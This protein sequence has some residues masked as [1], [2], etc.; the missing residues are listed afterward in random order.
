MG[1]RGGSR[2]RGPAPAATAAGRAAPATRAIPERASV[3]VRT[4]GARDPLLQ[5]I[6]ALRGEIAELR[7]EVGGIAEVVDGID[8]RLPGDELYCPLETPPMYLKRRGGVV[9]GDPDTV[10][11]PGGFRLG[12]PTKWADKDP[13]RRRD[14]F[15]HPLPDGQGFD[16]TRQGKPY[17]VTWHNVWRSQTLTREE[18][19]AQGLTLHQPGGRPAASDGGESAR[20]GAR[21]R[22]APARNATRSNGTAGRTGSTAR[23]AAAERQAQPAARGG[24]RAP[25]PKAAFL[26]WARET[27]QQPGG[28]LLLEATMLAGLGVSDWSDALARWGDWRGVARELQRRWAADGKE[29]GREVDDEEKGDG[30]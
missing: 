22:A 21:Q 16:M 4:D 5:E 7:G 6:G 18:A 14:G 8:L 2:Q 23:P 3:P 28:G 20:P 24:E 29:D 15:T 27:W 9:D 25:A 12:R 30:V 19:L 1:S 11:C 10:L 13:E 17:Y 26:G